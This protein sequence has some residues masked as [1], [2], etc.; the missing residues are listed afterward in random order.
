MNDGDFR[1]SVR[2]TIDTKDRAR[3]NHH[4]RVA[5]LLRKYDPREW[6][7]TET[8]VRE[9]LTGLR[10]NGAESV[11]YAPHLESEIEPDRDLLHKDGFDVHRFRA[12]LPILGSNETDR[13]RLVALGG[14]IM[15]FDAPLQ[16]LRDSSLDLIHTHALNRL[17][18]IGRFIARRRGIPFVVTIHGGYLD[19]PQTAAE[20]LA[21]PLREGFD[22]GKC[23]GWLLRSRHVVEDADAVITINPR[24]AELLRAAFPT[25]R[26]EQIPHGVPSARY[27][28]DQRQAAESCWPTIR[29]KT[30]LLLVARIDRLKNQGFLVDMLP[31]I[32]RRLPNAV[33]VL[34]GPVTDTE[35][36]RYVRSRV[37]ELGLENSV[38]LTGALAPEDPR[39]IGLYQCAHLFVLPSLTEPFGLVMLEAWAAGCPVIASATS[40]AKQ[41]IRKGEN[42]HM[43][44]PD[45]AHSFFEALGNVVENELHRKTLGEAGQRMVRTEFDSVVVARRVRNLYADLCATRKNKPVASTFADI[46]MQGGF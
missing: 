13:K 6:G 9:L 1:G 41:L 38:L 18:G 16:L 34:A 37:N 43:F 36:E 21:E 11:V 45:D 4:I 22:Y 46:T 39:L 32:K 44:Q 5:H 14:N 27:A 15:S 19:M 42:G 17:G 20:K 2:R 23:F 35:H 33:L 24:E 28:Q 30:I 3:A 31:E 7:G 29:G 12:F 8:A 25:L 40:G 10:A 26:V